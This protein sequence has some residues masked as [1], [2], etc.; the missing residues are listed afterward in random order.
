LPRRHLAEIE[1]WWRENRASG[2]TLLETELAAAI[3]L[4]EEHPEAGPPYRPPS[5][6]RRLLMPRTQYYVYYRV[7]RSKGFVRVVALWH[8]ARGR[9][10]RL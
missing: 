2:L 1:R 10:P 7:L 5:G 9:T 3:A 8:T 6:Y 4:L